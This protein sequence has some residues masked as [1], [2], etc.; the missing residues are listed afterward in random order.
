M[1][2]TE[3][4]YSN[5]IFYKIHCKNPDVK[6]V[7]IG[8]TTNFVQRKCAHKQSCTHENNSN[9]NCKVYNIIRQYGGWDNWKMEIIAFHD[10]E[11]HYTARKLE[12]KYFEEYNATMNSI[13]PLPKPKTIPQ[14][15]PVVYTKK[16][17]LNQEKSNANFTTDS[18]YEIDKTTDNHIKNDM[19]CFETQFAPKTYECIKCNFKCSK[20]SDWNRHIMTRKH[21][22]EINAKQHEA[23]TISSHKCK[24]CNDMFNSRTTLWRHTSRC[25][26]NQIIITNTTS[27]TISSF[28]NN[29]NR[30]IEQ[31]M[32]ANNEFNKMMIEQTNQMLELAKNTQVINNHAT[33]YTS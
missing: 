29:I 30:L 12:Q 31:Q 25:K 8:H 1:P 16:K 13:E 23:L 5:T 27:E 26:A 22:C 7:Y 15:E 6:D 2:K 18:A 28:M 11:D 4:D 24:F 17:I 10:C 32:T 20:Q 19:K 21:Y 33:T 9:Y 14:P 3:I